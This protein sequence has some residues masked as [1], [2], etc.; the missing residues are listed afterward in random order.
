VKESEVEGGELEGVIALHVEE[1]GGK[2][3]VVKVGEMVVAIELV[4]CSFLDS[5]VQFEFLESVAN[6]EGSC[7]S[8]GINNYQPLKGI[9]KK[10]PT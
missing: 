6:S 8:Y 5:R 10:Y 3:P 2:G 1:Q 9:Y 7:S 4:G